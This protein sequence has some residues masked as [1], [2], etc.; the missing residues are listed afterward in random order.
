MLEDR[1]VNIFEDGFESREFINVKDIVKGA[2]DSID[3]VKNNGETINLG[4]DINTS[5]IEIAEI[6]KKHYRS[7]FEI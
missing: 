4:S 5:V 2:I 1:T 3:E 6:L 7:W